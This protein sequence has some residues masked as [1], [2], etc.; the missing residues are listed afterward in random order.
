MALPT[1][2]NQVEV[3]LHPETDV[4]K[5][6]QQDLREI[7]SLKRRRRSWTI[8]ELENVLIL[9][10]RPLRVLPLTVS[11]K[12]EA[13]DIQWRLRRTTTI[14]GLILATAGDLLRLERFLSKEGQLAQ[15]TEKAARRLN[16]ETTRTLVSSTPATVTT[17]RM[18]IADRHP[19]VNGMIDADASESNR[20][21]VW[22][23]IL[24][25]HRDGIFETL[26]LS[27]RSKNFATIA[28]KK[29]LS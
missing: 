19:E 6:N 4:K 27:V 1:L 29:E 17:S 10:P 5:S 28:P 16:V 11:F 24:G 22:Q 13:I 18:G 15:N 21:L 12:E 7:T 14:L 20:H 2:L 25:I 26:T 23:L 3:A 8:L 9:Q